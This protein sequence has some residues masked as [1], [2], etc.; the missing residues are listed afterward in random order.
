ME[1]NSVLMITVGSANSPTHPFVCEKHNY[2]LVTLW[3]QELSWLTQ[4]KP[5][6]DSV[7]FI[8]CVATEGLLHDNAATARESAP[9]NRWPRKILS[10]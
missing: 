9:P 6:F 7:M 2:S 1:K 3:K 8:Y 5:T 4:R 10:S